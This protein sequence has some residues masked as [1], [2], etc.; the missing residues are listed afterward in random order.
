MF[1]DAKLA[2]ILSGFFADIA[3]AYFASIFISQT[4]EKF[5]NYFEV[6]IYLTKGA[7]VVILFLLLSWEFSKMEEKLKRKKIKKYEQY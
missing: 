2:K 5:T 1:L 7:L 3:K 4:S 6:V